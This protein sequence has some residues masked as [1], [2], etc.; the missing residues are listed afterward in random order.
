MA[1]GTGLTRVPDRGGELEPRRLRMTPS[2]PNAGTTPR[3]SRYRSCGRLEPKWLRIPTTLGAVTLTSGEVHSLEPGGCAKNTFPK[4]GKTSVKRVDF[5]T[6]PENTGKHW[7]DLTTKNTSPHQETFFRRNP[8]PDTHDPESSRQHRHRRSEASS[9][10]SECG[11]S[12]SDG[13]E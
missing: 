10:A 4:S 1:P 13:E 5:I 12:G 11:A 2:P 9:R 8:M 6:N 7:H 3:A